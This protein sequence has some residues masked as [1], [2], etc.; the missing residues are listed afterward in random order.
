MYASLCVGSKVKTENLTTKRVCQVELAESHRKEIDCQESQ[1]VLQ[2]PAVKLKSRQDALSQT[3]HRNLTLTNLEAEQCCK[4]R[5]KQ[6]K[7]FVKDLGSI[8]R[9]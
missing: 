8:E 2:R 5:S 1:I 4:E 3:I 9:K 7:D 6:G